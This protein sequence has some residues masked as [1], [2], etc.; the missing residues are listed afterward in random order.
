[1]R[2]Q[3]VSV[4]CSADQRSDCSSSRTAGGERKKTGVKLF[5]LGGRD[6]IGEQLA[7]PLDLRGARLHLPMTDNQSDELSQV[8]QD[9]T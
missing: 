2:G 3:A 9:G 4:E 6:S 7:K 1:M 8:L 5:S